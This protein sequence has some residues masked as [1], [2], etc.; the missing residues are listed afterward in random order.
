[1]LYIPSSVADWHMDQLAEEYRR[2]GNVPQWRFD[3]DV[4]AAQQRFYA[5]AGG[6]WSI[7]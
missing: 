6:R 7:P 4:K 3:M 2:M 1:M 5:R